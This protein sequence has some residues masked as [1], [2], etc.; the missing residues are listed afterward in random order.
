MSLLPPHALLKQPSIYP[1]AV[2]ENPCAQSGSTVRLIACGMV[3]LF[4]WIPALK[5][6]DLHGCVTI[7]DRNCGVFT[8][9]KVMHKLGLVLWFQ[10]H[11]DLSP[12]CCYVGCI[13]DGHFPSLSTGLLPNLVSTTT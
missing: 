13:A 6:D 8:V 12:H 3:R 4:L 9:S 10:K 7:L 11:Q 2:L 1:E 5:Q